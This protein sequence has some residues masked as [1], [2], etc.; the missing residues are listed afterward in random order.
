MKYYCLNYIYLIILILT[1]NS[2]SLLSD[3]QDTSKL[4]GITLDNV[5]PLTNIL[6]AL[7]H[8]SKKMTAR[9]VFDEWVPA[10]YYIASTTQIHLNSYIMGELLDSYYFSEY[11][12]NQYISRVNEYLNT[13]GTNVDIWEIGNEI[14]GE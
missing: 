1:L 14:N 6:Y 9:I 2:F 11:N 4:W 3:S 12:F 5:A 7:D 8:H 10:T 13:L